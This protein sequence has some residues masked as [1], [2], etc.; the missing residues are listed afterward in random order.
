ML[1]SAVTQK[2]LQDVVTGVQFVGRIL[3][4]HGS[5]HGRQMTEVKEWRMNEVT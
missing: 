2:E 5:A 1:L 4:F 3:S